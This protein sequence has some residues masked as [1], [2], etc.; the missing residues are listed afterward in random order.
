MTSSSVLQGQ[1]TTATNS[2][3]AL[4]LLVIPAIRP[5]AER[6]LPLRPSCIINP[7]LSLT[8]NLSSS[9]SSSDEEQDQEQQQWHPTAMAS[10]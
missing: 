1:V 4:A 3:P 7:V 8:Q 9:S 5:S 2:L 10:P 6:D